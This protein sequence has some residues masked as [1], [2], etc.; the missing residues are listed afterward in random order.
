MTANHQQ[1][2]ELIERIP[3]HR[4]ETAVRFLQF[5]LLD[6]VARAV[7]LARA[8]DELVTDEDRGRFRDAEAAQ[9]R[10]DQGVPMDEVLADFGLSMDDFPAPIDAG[11]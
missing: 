11:R 2:R 8:D 5:L 10:G 9:A 4:M 3:P 6:P 7:A 1:A